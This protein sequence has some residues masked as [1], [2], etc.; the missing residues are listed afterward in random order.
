M[1]NLGAIAGPVS[2]GVSINAS[3]V[4]AGGSTISDVNDPMFGFPDE[5]AVLWQN[6][7]IQDLGTLGG[8]NSWATI[9]NDRGQVTGG[10]L[11]AGNAHGDAFLWTNGAMSDL[12]TVTGDTD[13]YGYFVSNRGQVLGSSWN[14]TSERAFIWENGVMTDLNS[15]I[16]AN[17]GWQLLQAYAMNAHGQI[18]GIGSYNGFVQGFVLTPTTVSAAAAVTSA[19]ANLS[20]SVGIPSA[21]LVW[22]QPRWGHPSLGRGAAR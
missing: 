4:V 19:P 20:H 1:S 12:G 11:L 21:P 13:S 22:P 9:L 7:R 17:S 3:G 8:N 5:H 6:G 14:S 2:F 15:R 16:P 10:S 18:V